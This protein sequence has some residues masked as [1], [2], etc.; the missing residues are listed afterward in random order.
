[1]RTERRLGQ[2]AHVVE[3]AGG[4]L[5]AVTPRVVLLPG[6]QGDQQLGALREVFESGADRDDVSA[7]MAGAP[8]QITT[9]RAMSAREAD[10]T[11]TSARA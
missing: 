10:T 9:W 6:A 3:C 8:P 1:V 4:L 7:A 11:S 2:H 5:D